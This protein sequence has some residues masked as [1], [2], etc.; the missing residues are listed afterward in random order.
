MAVDVA[1]RSQG[2]PGADLMAGLSRRSRDVTAR[3]LQVLAE[4]AAPLPTRDIEEATGY[5]IRYGQLCYRMLCRLAR[6]GALVKIT[7]PDVRSRYWQLPAASPLPLGGRKAHAY[8]ESPPWR[9]ARHLTACGLEITDVDT[10][11]SWAA[12]D[13][14]AQAEKASGTPFWESRVCGKCNY[15]PKSGR[16][17]WAANPVLVVARSPQRLAFAELRALAALAAAHPDELAGL[18]EA[19]QVLLALGGL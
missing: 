4:A 9:A 3:I 5:G 13:R 2:P 12:F 16:A 17:T 11:L 15:E 8:R 19:E 1:T 10:V 6:L 18:L 7:L 14:M